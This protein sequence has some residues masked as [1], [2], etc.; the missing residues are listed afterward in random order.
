MGVRIEFVG[1][2]PRYLVAQILVV[3]MCV[4]AVSVAVGVSII[5]AGPGCKR[6]AATKAYQSIG[7]HRRSLCTS[8][9][10][11]VVHVG[12]GVVIACI[13]PDARVECRRECRRWLFLGG[14]TPSP[15]MCRRAVASKLARVPE[16]ARN[17]RATASRPS[18]VSR[19]V[20]C[21]CCQA[22]LPEWLL[23]SGSWS[24]GENW[25]ITQAHL[26]APG[27]RKQ[28][29]GIGKLINCFHQADL[30]LLPA[31]ADGSAPST[32]ETALVQVAK[33]AASSALVAA[34][35]PAKSP[36][37]SRGAFLTPP[38]KKARK[39]S[40]DALKAIISSNRSA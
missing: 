33:D 36:G 28:L 38:E 15:L 23:V 19:I 29:G 20:V 16:H 8:H 32:S 22:K 12:G 18:F 1:G 25:S 10:A 30:G 35:P 14:S 26:A 5:I 40:A 6:G 11:C 39:L 9:R 24:I 7:A 27:S 2:L 13:S 31:L 21:A 3:C 37:G 4:C 34:S 17:L